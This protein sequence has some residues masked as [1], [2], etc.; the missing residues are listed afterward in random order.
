MAASDTLDA[1]EAAAMPAIAG[2]G[3]RP[4]TGRKKL[5]VIG[6]AALLWL[7]ALGFAV[8]LIVGMVSHPAA[9][10]GAVDLPEIV[11]NLNAGPRRTS[12]V[13]LKAQPVLA[14]NADE[15]AVTAAEPR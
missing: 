15:A 10:S 1:D 6:A 7:G 12:F 4:K 14:N 13:R 11:S 3:R 5:L 8:K 9:T 2:A